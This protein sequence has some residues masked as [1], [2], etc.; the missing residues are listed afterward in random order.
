MLYNDTTN[1]TGICQE[2]DLICGSNTTSYPLADKNRRLNSALDDFVLMAVK[3]ASGWSIEDT[4]ETDLPVATRNLTSGTQDYAFPTELLVLEKLECL[5]S[6]GSTWIELKPT[7]QLDVNVPNGIP[8][9]Y[10]KVGNSFLLSPTPSYSV[11]SGLKAHYRRAF[12]YS[13]LSGS[14][15]TPTSPGI[16]SVF[17]TWLAQKAS[18]PYLIENSIDSRGDIANQILQGNDLIVAYFGKRPK[19]VKRRMVVSY[20]NNK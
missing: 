3:E 12:N 15:F 5:S 8:A 7:E 16:P 4:G 13:T 11:S 2:I 14:T 20:Q 10:K 18:L 19:D 17:H 9:E 6:D 1:K